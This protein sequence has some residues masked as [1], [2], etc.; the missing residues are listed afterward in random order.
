MSENASGENQQGD[1]R[2]RCMALPAARVGA[3]EAGLTALFRFLLPVS[4]ASNI[5]IEGILRGIQEN[6]HHAGVLN[7]LSA[8]ERA[9]RITTEA[10]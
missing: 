8:E 10:A 3:I 9:G 4:T 5:R 1:E 7:D 6:L 2:A